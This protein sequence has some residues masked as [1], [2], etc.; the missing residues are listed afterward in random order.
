MAPEEECILKVQLTGRG[1]ILG[2]NTSGQ[3]LSCGLIQDEV[4]PADSSSDNN[5]FSHMENTLHLDEKA[6]MTQKPGSLKSL[7]CPRSLEVDRCGTSL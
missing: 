4:R 6:S 3:L 2:K 1:L 7:D 5:S